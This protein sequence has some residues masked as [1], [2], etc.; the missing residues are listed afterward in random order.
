M[1]ATNELSR[2]I[3]TVVEPETSA[4]GSFVVQS[5]K[6]PSSE[7]RKIAE[8]TL[9][10]TMELDEDAS[11]ENF[12]DKLTDTVKGLPRYQE[13]K[14]K[15]DSVPDEAIGYALF[16]EIKM[17][18]DEPIDDDTI[19]EDGVLISSMRSGKLC[20]AGRT[21]IASAYLQERHI[22][23][24][25]VTAPGHNFLLIEQSPDTLAYFDSSRNL[26]FTFPRE[27]LRGYQGKDQVSECRLDEYTPRDKDA[28]D[29]LATPFFSAPINSLNTPL[30][31]FVTLPPNF[32]TMLPKDG[33][34]RTY[35]G[36]VQAALAGNKEF[37]KSNIAPNQEAARAI[38]DIE[39]D[40]LGKKDQILTSFLDRNESRI[41]MIEDQG[42]ADSRLIS[43][44]LG[45]HPTQDDFVESFAR[46]VQGD[47]GNRLV[48]L[49][50]ATNETRIAYGRRIWELLQVAKSAIV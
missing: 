32:I 27:A 17:A 15:L 7:A 21:L 29:G 3:N 23:H 48:Y 26:Y 37:R 41:R 39:A 44:L 18:N 14:A 50:N 31:N 4:E 33:I 30:T 46:V 16:Q 1:T 43:E 40:L 19:P 34:S 12:P 5:E 49:K 25:S 35:L 38:D 20:C 47:L 8:Q 22:D 9:R 36:N 11:L 10:Q 6:E 24:M 2:S 42:Q 28:V 45:Q 13:I